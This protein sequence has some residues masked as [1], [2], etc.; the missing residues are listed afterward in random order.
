MRGSRSSVDKSKRQPKRGAALVKGGSA[1]MFGP[2]AAGPD[3]PGRT[4]KVETPHLVRAPR[5][6]ARRRWLPLRPHDKQ[7]P[8]EPA[9]ASY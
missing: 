5:A 2:Q 3:R 7:S 1:K 4:G 8:A 6:A 9:H